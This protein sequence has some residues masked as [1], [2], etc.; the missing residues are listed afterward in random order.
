MSMMKGFILGAALALIAAAPQT[1]NE[2]YLA[3]VH[4]MEGLPQPS[5]VSYHMEGTSDGLSVGLFV[6]KG[7]VWLDI[8]K[9]SGRS[10]WAMRHRTY[11]YHSEIIENGGTRYVTARS[12][13]DPTWYGT[14][15]ALHEGMLG[16]QDP[17]PP[18]DMNATPSP[19]PPPELKTIA[20]TSVMGTETYHVE[21]R[22]ETHCA[23]GNPGRALHLWSVKHNDMHQLADVI[24]DEQNDRFCMMRYSIS[25]FFGFQGVVEQHFADVGGYW[26]QTD[27]LLDGTMRAFG[28]AFHHGVWRYKL[29]Q[30]TF[31]SSLPAEVFAKE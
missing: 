15:R 17:A 9:G 24:I 28:I 26:M 3:A 7:N 8:R 4:A 18:R 6:V 20:V 25:D 30:M 19:T 14:Y 2:R 21:D 5:Y 10:D 11:D 27:G 12:F 22:G 23:N 13:F 29:T 31:P 16:A 1:P